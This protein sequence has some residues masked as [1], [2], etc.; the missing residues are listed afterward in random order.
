[1]PTITA[2]LAPTAKPQA[3]SLWLKAGGSRVLE[4]PDY[5]VPKVGFDS[6]RTIEPGVIEISSPMLVC[7]TGAEPQQV[8]LK[9]LRAN[10]SFT[11]ICKDYSVLPNDTVLIPVQG[12]FLLTGDAVE[13]SASVDDVLHSTVSFTVGQAESEI[14]E[15]DV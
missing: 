14:L 10:G 11:F 7:N 12:Q 1:M 4:V 15:G 3:L 2:R 6:G 13:V 5:D 8:T 9:I